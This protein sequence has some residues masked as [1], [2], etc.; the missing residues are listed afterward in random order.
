MV[1]LVE[2]SFK[3]MYSIPFSSSESKGSDHS[4]FDKTKPKIKIRGM[5]LKLTILVGFER[6]LKT[7]FPSS[8]VGMRG[9]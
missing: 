6:V 3:K 7:I 5:R 9:E 8:K 2:M 4:C 1:E